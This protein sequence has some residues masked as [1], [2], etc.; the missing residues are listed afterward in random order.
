MWPEA[1]R[2]GPRKGSDLTSSMTRKVLTIIVS[3]AAL[4]HTKIFRKRLR[5]KGILLSIRARG[6]R[7]NVTNSSYSLNAIGF[8]DPMTELL[9]QVANVHIDA[10]IEGGGTASQNLLGK[11][12][13]CQ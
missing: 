5:S 3:I 11:F 4:N 13:T 7:I 10:P 12:F 9:A 2:C 8:T 1:S 6:L